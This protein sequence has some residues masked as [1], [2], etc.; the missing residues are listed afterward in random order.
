MPIDIER[1]RELRVK[2]NLT[3]QAA[4]DAVGFSSRQVWYQLESGVLDN[5]TVATLERIAAVLGVKAKDLLK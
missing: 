4:A 3:Q 1:I 2:K 5:I